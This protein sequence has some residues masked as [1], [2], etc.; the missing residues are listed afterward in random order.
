MSSWDHFDHGAD[1]G[2][3]GRGPSRAE[4]FRQAALALAALVVDPASVK[5]ARRFAIECKA[6][7][8]DILLLDWLNRLVYLMSG[9]DMVF[10]DFNV[11]ISDGVLRAEAS[12]ETVDRQRHIVGVEPKGATYTE[13]GVSKTAAGEWIAQCVIDV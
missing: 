10:H 9:E 6:P 8:D 7:D 11:A 12:G 2:V 1:I 5:A 13:L 3:R 4:A